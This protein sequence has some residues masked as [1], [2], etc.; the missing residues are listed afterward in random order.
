MYLYISFFGLTQVCQN[1]EIITF[2]V[3]A[4]VFWTEVVPFHKLGQFIKRDSSSPCDNL[5]P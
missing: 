5:L 1:N 4:K 3:H 2:S